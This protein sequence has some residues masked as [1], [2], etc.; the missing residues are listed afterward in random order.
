MGMV[1][2]VRWKKWY[3]AEPKKATN[4]LCAPQLN[5]YLSP[6]S[7]YPED[8]SHNPVFSEWPQI[9]R[10]LTFLPLLSLYQNLA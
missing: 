3:L 1:K 2:F 10:S 7:Y 5:L 9:K 4:E 8:I 6:D